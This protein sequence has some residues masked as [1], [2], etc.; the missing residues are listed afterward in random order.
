[1]HTKA[2]AD[3]KK[4]QGNNATDTPTTTT[5]SA[6]EGVETDAGRPEGDQETTAST[7]R[8]ELIEI[9]QDADSPGDG[10]EDDDEDL[11]SDR[12]EEGGH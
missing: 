11:I 1:M 2:C 12:E 6:V 5:V 8:E 9:D 3:A 10:E 4:T 7:Q